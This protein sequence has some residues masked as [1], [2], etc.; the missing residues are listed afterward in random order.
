MMLATKL[1]QYN[2]TSERRQSP[3][4]NKIASKLAGPKVSIIQ[5]SDICVNIHT[6]TLHAG[7]S[8]EIIIHVHSYVATCEE[9][10]SE[11]TKGCMIKTS[12]Q[13]SSSNRIM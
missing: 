8:I 3:Y 10:Q 4:N 1:C 11:V 6:I 9:E 12:F 7:N 2:F 13:L 5:S